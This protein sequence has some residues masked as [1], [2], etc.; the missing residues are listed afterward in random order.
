MT[1]ER[2]LLR[3][4]PTVGA[5]VNK[6]VLIGL[7]GVDLFFV[8]SGFLITGILIN[9]KNSNRF[10]LNFYARR[11]LRIFPLY[12]L[13]LFAVFFVL[14]LFIRFDD[15][16]QLLS[17]QQWWLWTYLC[18]LPMSPT[19]DGSAVLKMG[20]FWSLAVEEHF[21]L[22]WPAFVY[23]LDSR[24]LMRISLF[25]YVISFGLGLFGAQLDGS[26][27]WPLRWSTIVHSGGLALGAYCALAV[28][29]EH[30]F[31]RLYLLAK[32]LLLPSTFA[33]FALSFIP[34]RFH[35]EIVASILSPVAALFFTV[36]LVYCLLA[37]PECVVGRFFNA[38]F[39]RY[40]GKIS[41]GLYV[42]HGLLRP[43]FEWLFPRQVL[44]DRTGSP[45]LGILLY[46]TLSI[47][48]AYLISSLSWSLFEKQVLK[49]KRFFENK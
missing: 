36:L 35:T 11:F 19:W 17:K 1:G 25:W 48:A 18:N 46:F 12:Y 4:F 14:P 13:T 7:K 26:I 21:Y 39:M 6:F 23:C 45:L 41:Y 32:R 9:S 15:K 42:Y 10:F 34:R 5:W 24:K 16:L 29:R 2:I 31:D 37:T 49:L 44:I 38:K 27:W 22:V 20:H 28:R 8:L 3:F 43:T 30:G 40:T 33:F 47:G